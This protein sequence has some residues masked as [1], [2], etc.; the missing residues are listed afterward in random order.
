[1]LTENEKIFLLGIT[2]KV[3]E[4]FQESREKILDQY[5]FTFLKGEIEYEGFLKELIKKLD[6]GV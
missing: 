4:D 2:K 5:P 1:M 6:K 3:L